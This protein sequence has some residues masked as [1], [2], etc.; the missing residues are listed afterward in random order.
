MLGF[1]NGEERFPRMGH[2]DY[3]WEYLS[4]DGHQSRNIEERPAPTLQSITNPTI[5]ALFA[6]AQKLFGAAAAE[7]TP[8]AIQDSVRA[9]ISFH[10]SDNGAGTKSSTVAWE[11]FGLS[12]DDP[13]IGLVE[14]Y[15]RELGQIGQS[16]K[17]AG[18]DHYS[19]LSEDEVPIAPVAED[20]LTAMTPKQVAK[21]I[22]AIGRGKRKGLRM[23]R[24]A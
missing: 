19:L 14:V 22:R 3:E 18:P 6:E 5:Q 10:Q 13:N 23:H 17:P 16:I 7:T 1:S 11:V 2:P 9:S 20:G 15:L 12:P 24:A 21:A 8:D 4:G